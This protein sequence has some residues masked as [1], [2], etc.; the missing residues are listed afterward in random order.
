VV[1]SICE[2]DSTVDNRLLSALDHHMQSGGKRSRA[3][4]CVECGEKTGISVN[5][6]IYLAACV[7]CLHNAS[8]IQDDLQD[9]SGNRRGRIAV[10]K[11]FGLDTTLCLID[12]LVSA[13]Y[14]SLAKLEKSDSLPALISRVHQ[15]IS[16]TLRGQMADTSEAGCE[17]KSV[18]YFVDI[19]QAKSGPFFALAMELPLIAS[20]NEGCLEIARSAA[21]HFATGYQIFDDIVDL[22]QD[23]QEGNNHNIVIAFGKSEGAKRAVKRAGRMALKHLEVSGEESEKLPCDCGTA[24]IQRISLLR[25]A[26]ENHSG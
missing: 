8:L 26:L 6:S 4:L 13:A 21:V 25:Q 16:Q 10:W 1:R 14:G 15:A 24:L 22:E 11:T 18:G 5:D 23:R 17:D 3:M 19:A 12:L 7:E 20:G 2:D 9:C